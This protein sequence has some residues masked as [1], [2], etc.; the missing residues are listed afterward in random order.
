MKRPQILVTNDDGIESPG[1]RAAA[2]ALSP[3]GDLV[4]VAPQ[5]QQSGAGRGIWGGEH[6]RVWPVAYE[7]SGVGIPAYTCA[8]SPALT[9]LMG[10]VALFNGRKPDLLV[11]GINYGENLGLNVTFSGTVGAALQGASM[12]VRALAVSLQTDKAFLYRYGEV[13]WRAA[14][15]FAAR[16]AGAL[17]SE[18]LPHDVDVLKVDVPS[19]ATSQTPWKVTRIARQEYFSKRFDAPSP[20]TRVR[21]GVV[22]VQLDPEALEEDSDIH[23]IV[24]ERVV[25]VTPV[26]LDM[27]S[28]VSLGAL[29]NRLR[30]AAR[31]A[32]VAG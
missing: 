10:M 29:E 16:F 11:S 1:L 28:R 23:A 6:E 14:E 9:V 12:G 31:R 17:L 2:R 30:S 25:S 3:V 5:T 21:D 8:A 19:D 18:A 15:H 32:D 13:D 27:T 26:S 24:N 20:E 7:L 4:I 22:D